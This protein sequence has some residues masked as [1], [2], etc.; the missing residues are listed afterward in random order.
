MESRRFFFFSFC[1]WAF[2]EDVCMLMEKYSRP[3]VEGREEEE[4]KNECV[5]EKVGKVEAG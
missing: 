2:L 4:K 3:R 1:R 5:P